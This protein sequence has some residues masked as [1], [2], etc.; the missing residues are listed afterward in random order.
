MKLIGYILALSIAGCAWQPRPVGPAAP[1]APGAAAVITEQGDR[2]SEAI[3]YNGLLGHGIQTAP[4]TPIVQYQP[5]VEKQAASLDQAKAGEKAAAEAME[6]R[7]SEWAGI[8][9]GRDQRIADGDKAYEQ[10]AGKWYV[11]WG[12]WIERI[13]WTLAI[14]WGVLGIL[15]VVLGMGNPLGWASTASKEI[16]RLMPAANPFAWIRDGINAF[17]KKRSA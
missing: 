12:K 3:A 7:E 17:R 13:L 14:G 4:Q 1:T 9:K 16:V 6:R 15:S 5:V 10:L 8:V 2:I 11:V